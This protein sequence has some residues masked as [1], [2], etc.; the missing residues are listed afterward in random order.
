[1]GITWYAYPISGRDQGG[2]N[3]VIGSILEMHIPGQIH[4][5]NALDKGGYSTVNAPQSD[6]NG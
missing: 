6:N 1:M 5:S 2:A 3:N 4:I